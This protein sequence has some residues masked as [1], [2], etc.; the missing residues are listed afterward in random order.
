MLLKS[1]FC[2]YRFTAVFLQIN[3]K[4]GFC[5]FGNV[6]FILIRIFVEYPEG[7]NESPGADPPDHVVQG[8][9]L[10]V[11]QER[12][13]T[14]G[15]G[16]A[17]EVG[18]ALWGRRGTQQRGRAVHRGPHWHDETEDDDDQEARYNHYTMWC[19]LRQLVLCCWIYARYISFSLWIMRR[20]WVFGDHG[21]LFIM[22]F[23]FGVFFKV[24]I[25]K[26]HW[27]ILNLFTRKMKVSK[28]ETW[29]YSCCSLLTCSGCAWALI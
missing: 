8:P 23:L 16:D 25:K 4:T 3:Y 26:H 6:H 12:C 1:Y 22:L 15:D 28:Q 5:Y 29:V 9:R 2:P 7:T 13:E 17:P 21:T 14:H 24:F 10:A 18:R 20:K 19:S 11:L 27:L